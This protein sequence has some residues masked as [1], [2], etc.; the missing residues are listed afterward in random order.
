[1]NKS[2]LWS[3]IASAHDEFLTANY[4]TLDLDGAHWVMDRASYMEIRTQAERERLTREVQAQIAEAFLKRQLPADALTAVP[5][6]GPLYMPPDWFAREPDPGDML[7]GLPILVTRDGGTPH[8]VAGPVPV[9]ASGISG[10]A[11]G[12]GGLT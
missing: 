1:M 12:T 5:E 9:A 11:C 6:T 4:G 10:G 7:L 8:L 2:S 3:R